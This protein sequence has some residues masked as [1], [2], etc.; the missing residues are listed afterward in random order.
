MNWMNCILLLRTWWSA[1]RR[2][3]NVSAWHGA[4]VLPHIN[5]VTVGYQQPTSQPVRARRSHLRARF[6]CVSCVSEVPDEWGQHVC[7]C[8]LCWRNNNHLAI[9]RHDNSKV[10]KRL[11]GVLGEGER[12][13]ERREEWKCIYKMRI[14]RLD[15]IAESLISRRQ[16]HHKLKS[17]CTP[18][19]G[20]SPPSVLFWKM[21]QRWFSHRH[22][23]K[24]G[25]AV[26]GLL[27]KTSVL[28]LSVMKARHYL[29]KGPL[30][31]SRGSP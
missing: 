19:F 11:R 22:K 10:L 27:A 25:A 6:V 26:Q 7:S 23:G 2:H 3:T 24:A 12:E 5:P 15:K 4:C 18:S 29:L 30:Q 31:T 28:Y 16:P 13:G 14:T 20:R 17:S 8:G 1:R 21:Q 9:D